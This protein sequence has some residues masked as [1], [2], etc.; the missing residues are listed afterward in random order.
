MHDQSHQGH[1]IHVDGPNV[2]YSARMGS[3]LFVIGL[4]AAIHSCND[5][6]VIKTNCG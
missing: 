1:S 6:N 5:V 2:T 3:M 4:C